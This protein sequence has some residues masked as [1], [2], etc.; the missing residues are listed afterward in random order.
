M[1]P[2]LQLLLISLL[3]WA[4]GYVCFCRGYYIGYLRGR[5]EEQRSNHK[6]SVLLV[7]KTGAPWTHSRS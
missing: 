5:A 1:T 3:L 7:R 6:R 2:I 4:L